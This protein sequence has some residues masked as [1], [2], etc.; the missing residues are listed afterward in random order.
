M[1]KCIR[2][3][4]LVDTNRKICPLCFDVLKKT[5]EEPMKHS[6]YPEYALVPTKRSIFL[7]IL[8]FFTILGIIASVLVNIFTYHESGR[9]WSIIVILALGYL[10][11]LIKSTIISQSNVAIRLLVQ[12]FAISAV[13]IGIDEVTGYS[14]WSIN[15]I[16]PFLSMA[17]LMAIIL[18]FLIK[19]RI[20]PPQI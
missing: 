11:I 12:M 6:R 4:V 5:D 15:Y 3:N 7:R 10:W 1:K 9:L 20:Y 14:G 19:V 2:C 18:V 16:I 8:G 17:A 13:V